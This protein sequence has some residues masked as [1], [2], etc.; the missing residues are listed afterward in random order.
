M[1][2]TLPQWLCVPE[3]EIC[4]AGA[5][6]GLAICSLHWPFGWDLLPQEL[7][8]YQTEVSD[9]EWISLAVLKTSS[10]RF[11]F[12]ILKLPI[13]GGQLYI[14]NSPKLIAAIE[15]QPNAVSFWH[16]EAGSI[17][18]IAGLRPDALDTVSRGV[19][20]D[21]NSFWLKGLRA[22]HHAMAPSAGVNDM[23]LK[24]A[25]TSTES[26][27]HCHPQSGGRGVDLWRWVTHEITLA[28]TNAVYGHRNPYKDPQIESAFWLVLIVFEKDVR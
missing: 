27:R 24:A 3:S 12:P 5:T 16:V 19:G 23:I 18:K 7:L 4:F 15:R 11:Q 13:L 10:K 26:L 20:D 21:T 2:D 14:V 8:L 22:I 9:V 28:H 1:S 6:P 17:G 25:Q